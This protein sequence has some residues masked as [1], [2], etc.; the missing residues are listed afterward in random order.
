MAVLMAYHPSINSSWV[1]AI[2][3]HLVNLIDRGMH[4]QVA[5]EASGKSDSNPGVI[6]LDPVKSPVVPPPFSQFL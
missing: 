5:L 3:I 1:S 6:F 4:S 2:T